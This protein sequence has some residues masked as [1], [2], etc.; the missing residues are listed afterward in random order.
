AGA[1]PTEGD[2]VEIAHG[3][4]PH[5]SRNGPGGPNRYWLFS[6]GFL[7]G[8]H[9]FGRPRKPWQGYPLEAWAAEIKSRLTV[10]VN[11][12]VHEFRRPF[13]QMRSHSFSSPP[14]PASS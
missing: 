8:G 13:H 11:E 7:I 14:S 1:Q 5:S 3:E 4:R 10:A 12:P 6:A 9:E 2:A